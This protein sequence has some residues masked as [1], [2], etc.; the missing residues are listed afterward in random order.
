M[1]TLSVTFSFV[2]MGF[3][4]IQPVLTVN[5]YIENII[6]ALNVELFFLFHEYIFVYNVY[7]GGRE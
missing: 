4:I 5:F 7:M 2:V 3:F 1:I 6:S